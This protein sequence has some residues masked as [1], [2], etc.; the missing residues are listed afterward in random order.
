MCGAIHPLPHTSWHGAKISTEYVFIAWY[1]VKHS[2]FIIYH[3]IH[4]FIQ[5]LFTASKVVSF[6]NAAVPQPL[7]HEYVKCI[8]ISPKSLLCGS[9]KEFRTFRRNV[10]FSWGSKWRKSSVGWFIQRQNSHGFD[11]YRMKQRNVI[12][13]SCVNSCG[14]T[15]CDFEWSSMQALTTTNVATYL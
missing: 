5:G 12:S 3:I 1:L 7:R 4:I 15:R 8:N 10:L 14:S 2:D 9:G 11:W 6:E 13:Q